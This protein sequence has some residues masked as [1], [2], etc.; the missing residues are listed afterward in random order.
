MSKYSTYGARADE[1]ARAAFKE[2][3]D[4]S[5]KL[6]D[7]ESKAQAYPQRSGIVDTAYAAKSARAAA[8]LAEAKENYNKAKQGIV[9]LNNELAK[10]RTDLQRELAKDNRADPEA[11]D[12]ATMDLLKSGI[13][14]C[15][16]YIGLFE[17]HSGNRTMQRLIKSY[18]MTAADNMHNTDD[19]QRLKAVALGMN[20]DS[21]TLH[22]FDVVAEVCRRVEHNTG[23]IQHYDELTASALQ[24]I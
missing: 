4:A 20:T 5:K 11:V 17:R 23:M 3:M 22:N 18:A 10:L 12:T 6:A 19:R 21:E 2:V 15:D 9:T 24:N 14:N 13:L 1:L 7:A 8:D 16:D